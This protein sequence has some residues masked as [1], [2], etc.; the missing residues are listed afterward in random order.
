MEKKNTNPRQQQLILPQY[1]SKCHT[2]HLSSYCFSFFHS[3][4]QVVQDIVSLLLI[5]LSPYSGIIVYSRAADVHCSRQINPLPLRWSTSMFLRTNLFS[6]HTYM[7]VAS[8][9]FSSM[10]YFMRKTWRIVTGKLSL[11]LFS[12]G[13][14]KSEV[15]LHKG[16]NYTIV[17]LS[18]LISRCISKLQLA[19]LLRMVWKYLME[20]RP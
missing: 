14:Q 2:I 4:V 11:L 6:F 3:K 20:K 17:S 12:F 8:S 9:A 10:A 19:Q 7:K 5:C 16:S 13:V 15:I 1:L 18:I